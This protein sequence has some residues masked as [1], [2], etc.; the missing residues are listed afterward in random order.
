MLWFF[1]QE[2]QHNHHHVAEACLTGMLEHWL[3]Q[4]DPPPSW[5]AL[6]EALRSPA[7][8]RGNIAS[9]IDIRISTTET[10]DK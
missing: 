4:A 8:D 1:Q 9:E 10:M 3:T 2:I 7:L 6:I 5:L